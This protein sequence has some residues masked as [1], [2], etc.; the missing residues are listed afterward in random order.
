[1]K[2]FF[3]PKKRRYTVII[4]Y[5]FL[6]GAI[7]IILSNKMIDYTSTD[8]FCMSCHVHPHAEDAWRLSTHYDN[9]SGI[10]VHCVEC[11]LPPPGSLNYLKTKAVTGARDVYG[12]IFKD[13]EKINW[14]AKRQLSQ[15]VK[16]TFQESCKSCH[17]NLFPIQL[18]EEGMQAHLY[19]AD[20]EEELNCLNCHLHVGHYSDIPHE[21]MQV[22][23]VEVTE[24]T[25]TFETAAEVTAFE[26]FTETIP[27]TGIEFNMLPIPGGE[28]TIGSP[29]NEPGRSENEGP[30]RTIELSSYFMAEIEITW[31]M[32]MAFFNETVSEGRSDQSSFVRTGERYEDL[33]AISG[34]TP[35]WGSPDQGWGWGNRP[36]ITMTHYGAETFCEW[37]SLKTGKEYRLPT[38]A[39]WEFAAR[40]NTSTPYFFEGN[41]KKFSNERF[42]NRIFGVDTTNINTYVIYAENSLARSQTPDEV[43]PN[44]FGLKN[45]LG[46]IW[47]YCAD[48]YAEDA[49][50]M[51]PDGQAVK[52]PKGPDSGTERV[53]R[54]GSFNSDAYEVR[55]AVRRPTEHDEWLRTDPQIP[56]SIWWYSDTNEVG[57]RVVLNWPVE[58]R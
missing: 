12:T 51:Y 46:N 33:D 13:P 36:A 4:L 58:K 10:V 5:G 53:I 23:T 43:A 42:F 6:I 30:T 14:A 56:K 50:A 39:E 8:E 7:F 18:S 37:L 3:I 57:F 19:Y 44:P 11:H 22:G 31:D 52:D 55:S 49:Y 29:A 28:F 47:E 32:Y 26:P 9:K 34:P 16:H 54:G 17:Q 48:Y 45:M 2:N 1:M 38:E 25:V 27:G 20:N 24:P 41:P 35:P 21:P 15:A 40:G